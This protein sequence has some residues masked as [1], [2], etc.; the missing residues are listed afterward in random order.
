MPRKSSEIYL[1]TSFESQSLGHK[2]K[3]CSLAGLLLFQPKSHE[4]KAAGVTNRKVPR[5]KFQDL[6]QSLKTCFK[7]TI[8][9]AFLRDRKQVIQQRT[10]L[11]ITTWTGISPALIPPC[12]YWQC[13]TSKNNPVDLSFNREGSAGHHSFGHKCLNNQFCCWA[14]ILKNI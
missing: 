7:F 3:R 9:G 6:F 8:W 11:I 12:T 4:K 1:F 14:V 5:I 2:E 13:C 10:S